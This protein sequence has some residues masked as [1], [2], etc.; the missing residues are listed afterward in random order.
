M[1]EE[2]KDLRGWLHAVRIGRS[3]FRVDK[4]LVLGDSRNRKGIIVT[5]LVASPPSGRRL[6]IKFFDLVESLT[7]EPGPRVPRNMFLAVG[8]P[9]IPRNSY[10]GPSEPAAKCVFVEVRGTR[11]E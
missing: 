6:R 2:V 11:V 5:F 4:A 1:V 7:T 10:D 8:I 9:R 3:A